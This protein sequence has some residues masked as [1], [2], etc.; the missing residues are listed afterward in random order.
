MSVTTTTTIET[1]IF[2]ALEQLEA[3]PESIT[4]EAGF[5]QLDIDSLDLAEL[6]QIIDEEYGVKIKGADM[7]SLK[8]VGD[9]IDYV[10]ARAA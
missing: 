10:A 6:A 9:V 8:T 7:E 4:R 3:E 1:T 2:K 5:E